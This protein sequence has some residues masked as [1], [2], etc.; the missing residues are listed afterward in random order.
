MNATYTTEGRAECAAATTQNPPHRPRRAMQ[1]HP[2]KL[3]AIVLAWMLAVLW[4]G[5]V[6]AQS[7][8][9]TFVGPDPAFPAP[10]LAKV[11]DHGEVVGHY[12]PDWGMAKP[13]VWRN[14]AFTALPLLPG[15][16]G[17]VARAN[18]SAGQIVGSCFDEGGASQA[19]L[20][21]NGAV[22]ALPMPAGATQSEAF[23]INNAG[24][25]TGSGLVP[26]GVYPD[27]TVAYRQDAV[28]WQGG[29]VSVIAPPWEPVD[30]YPQA[31]D[32]FGRVAV[33]I[34]NDWTGEWIPARW[35]PDV[36]N[37]STGT[38]EILDSAGFGSDIND[39]G[40]VCGYDS[41]QRAVLWNVSTPTVI[42]VLPGD[43]WALAQSIN[44][45]STVVGIS[46]FYD[47]AAE[48]RSTA[49][50]WTAEDGMRDLNALMNN[51]VGGQSSLTNAL[52][53]N[54]AGQILAMSDNAYVLLNPS[55][56]LPPLPAP[57]GLSS[58]A[59]DSAVALSW[60]TVTVATA[61]NVKR[62]TTSGGPYTT[63]AAGVSG[64]NYLDGTAVNGIR[65]YYV[66]TAV[67]ASRESAN[68]NE[69]S[70]KPLATPLAP[71]RLAAKVAKAKVTLTWS[72]STS[73]EIQ[74]NRV[75]RSTNGGAFVM[76][77][78][79]P[80]G[81]TWSDS[82]VSSKTPYRYVVTAVNT[83]G[84]ESPASNAVSA[85]PK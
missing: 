57:T 20:W 10:S 82:S 29:T 49:F 32:A 5:W 85:T 18:N 7:Y 65:Y 47:L 19:C 16:S 1:I 81:L 67:D 56:L 37:G 50:V 42:G 74:R 33:A 61:Y 69:T 13:L 34:P 3:A 54:N 58:H 39:S 24:G 51:N 14:G 36:P 27:G 23:D 79:I 9:A 35:T 12:Y 31:I 4:P 26:A 40:V 68:S 28:V 64:T 73:P 41:L 70:A 62:S 21:E 8:T 48:T 60:N 75:F 22:T 59:G 43:V 63:I 66:V 53:I 6:G 2:A 84:L 71:T 77:A 17:G 55:P 11:N 46:V 78:S 76:I 44:G 38:F 30:L 80:A 83:L 15:T 52:A 25:V 72:Q 45:N